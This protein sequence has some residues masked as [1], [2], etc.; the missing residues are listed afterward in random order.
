MSNDYVIDVGALRPGVLLPGRRIEGEAPDTWSL[1]I[2]WSAVDNLFLSTGYLGGAEWTAKHLAENEDNAERAQLQFVWSLPVPDTSEQSITLR[3][4]AICHRQGR[5]GKGIIPPGTGLAAF[6]DLGKWV[7]HWAVVAGGADNGRWW[8]VD[9]GT[10]RTETDHMAEDAAIM[11]AMRQFH[12]RMEKG[13]ADVSGE[14]WEPALCLVDSGKW[15]EVVYDFMKERA[16]AG[17]SGWFAAKGHGVSQDQG[18]VYAEPQK[19]DEKRVLVIGDRYHLAR[20]EAKGI[21][22]LHTDVDHWK[23]RVHAALRVDVGEPGSLVLWK[24]DW[25]KHMGIA[26]SLLAEIEVEEFVAA[27]GTVVKWVKKHRGNHWFDC[28]VGAFVA[29]DYLALLGNLGKGE[30]RRVK[31]ERE[32]GRVRGERRRVEVP[33]FGGMLKR[34]R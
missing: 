12:E 21:V 30:E 22:L 2:R 24:E 27:R 4:D 16:A 20:Q 6:L 10:I 5:F 19:A 23:S 9:A 32:E 28:V 14:V 18:R 3:A 7:C 17:D 31:G 1:S 26:R 25:K 8:V 11:V 29:L 34:D 33:G 15:T 13:F